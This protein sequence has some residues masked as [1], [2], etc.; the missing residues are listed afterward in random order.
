MIYQYVAID[1]QGESFKGWTIGNSLVAVQK[2]LA[3]QG[4]IILSISPWKTLISMR[5]SRSITMKTL[6]FFA[7]QMHQLMKAGLTLPKAIEA[8]R[9]A[10]PEYHEL[11]PYLEDLNLR[12]SQGESI[13][14]A[15]FKNVKY[16][17]PIV[18]IA[19][20]RIDRSLSGDLIDTWSKISIWA[21]QINENRERVLQALT[22]PIVILV[23]AFVIIIT[24]LATVVP[25]FG[26]LFT[27]LFGPNSEIP[28][29][30]LLLLK[31]SNLLTNHPIY[32]SLASLSTLIMLYFLTRTNIWKLLLEK[33]LQFKPI[34][35]FFGGIRTT[36][37]FESL[38]L[39]LK[40]GLTLPK[41]IESLQSVH[42]FYGSRHLCE[43]ALQHLNSGRSF[44]SW[45]QTV[46][47][48][49]PTSISLVQS[50]EN[51]GQFHE[52]FARISEYER[53]Q[54]QQRIK[55]CITLLE[56]LCILVLTGIIA[57]FVILLFQPLW[58]LMDGLSI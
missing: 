1:K 36:Y 52:T 18:Y 55:T 10:L 27:T 44:S 51:S 48:F 38:Y 8:I 43:Q 35:Y 39:L 57:L 49:H 2:R 24:L 58:H 28:P 54:F 53:Q 22:Y 4:K 13:G 30:T 26:D 47:L 14:E 37:F 21:S 42:L 34:Q 45:M 6:S 41:A 16:W 25:S 46:S 50:A 12:L 7:Y 23:F 32:I 15:F 19:L 20:Q 9:Q 17:G 11:H 5:Q 33:M 29:A 3:A 56:P 31:S 40:S